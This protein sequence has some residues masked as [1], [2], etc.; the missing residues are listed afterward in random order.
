MAKRSEIHFQQ[1]V[2]L[3]DFQSKYGTEEQCQKHLFQLKWPNGYCC[4]RCAHK[5][6]YF[7]R[8]RSLYQCQNCR[9]QTSLISGTIFSST[10][11]PLTVWFLAIY[12]VS[13]SKKGISSL[14]LM[15]FLGISQN[16][17]MRL[18]H[19]LQMV[20]KQADD[21]KPLKGFIQVDDV[22]WGG[23]HSGG[24]RGRGAEGKTPFIA[25]LERNEKGNPLF[26]RFSRIGAFTIDQIQRWGERHL[27]SQSLVVSDGLACFA[28]FQAINHS[29]F[30]INTTSRYRNSDFTFFD[31]LNTVI[32][33]VKNAML[34]T[35]HGIC[36]RHLPRYLGE[37][38]FRFNRRFKLPILLNSLIYYSVKSNPIPE[39]QLRRAEDWW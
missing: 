34:S 14:K 6:Y 38:C 1:G 24:K 27:I 28:G 20:M 26:I 9:S 17:A 35:Y 33:N 39:R 36:H 16:A 13:Q 30:S 29:H 10:K 11:L 2:S 12:L 8:S 19:K 15:R 18:K 3:L 23:K 25:A 5:Q 21:E 4:P 22:Y 37:F 31:W 32:G 7:V